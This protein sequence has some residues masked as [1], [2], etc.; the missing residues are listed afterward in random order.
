MGLAP[1]VISMVTWNRVEATKKCI[2]SII[3]RT[4]R[5]YRLIVTD[6]GSTD[7][8]KAYLQEL[9]DDG[10]V[11]SVA[12]LDKNVGVAKGRNAHWPLVKGHDVMRLDNDVEILSDDWL[13]TLKDQSD[14]VHGVIGLLIDSFKKAV[15]HET[16][17]SNGL[18]AHFEVAG[19]GF[20]I[21]QECVDKLSPWNEEY[22]MHGYE[23]LDYVKRCEQLGYAPYLNTTVDFKH[24]YPEAYGRT[25]SERMV[26]RK[27]FHDNCQLYL[28]GDKPL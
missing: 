28:D 14:K 1:I 27:L 8:T 26:M 9:W 17:N 13:T 25:Q 19:T 12:F 5:P 3:S 21:P 20:F 11:D 23:D 24:L 10:V 15:Q 18:V 16:E 7:S 4:K 2:G 22:G 6:N